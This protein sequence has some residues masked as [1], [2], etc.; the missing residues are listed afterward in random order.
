M[1]AEPPSLGIRRAGYSAL[2]RP[3][4][5]IGTMPYVHSIFAFDEV[6]NFHTRRA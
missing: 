1:A 6:E 2:L 3:L 4:N 5:F